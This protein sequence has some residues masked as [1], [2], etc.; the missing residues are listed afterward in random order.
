MG[1]LYTNADGL[2]QNYGTRSAENAV[3]GVVEMDGFKG[4]LVVDFDYTT[5]ALVGYVAARSDNAL[6]P[7]GAVIEAIDLVVGTAWVGGTSLALNFEDS[8]GATTPAAGLAATATAVLLAG[9]AFQGAGAA[10]GADIPSANSDVA[11]NTLVVGTFTAGTAK[12]V[13]SF[14][15]PR[16]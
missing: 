4:Q 2:V 3:A 14:R 7:A 12:A 9:A 10:V 8:A 11:L 6:I 5:T 15:M 1:T 13:V 16:A